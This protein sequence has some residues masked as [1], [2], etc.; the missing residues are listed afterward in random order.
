M[1]KPSKQNILPGADEALVVQLRQE[2]ISQQQ[3][4]QS[5]TPLVQRF[6]ETQA[7]LVAD[8]LVQGMSQLRF[9]LPDKVVFLVGRKGEGQSAPLP[10]EFREQLVG[11]LMDR[12][13]GMDIRAAMRQRLAELEQSVN[14]AVAASAGLL[15]YATV[16]HMV[17]SMLPAGKSV[18]Y[19]VD[20]EDEIPNIPAGSDLEVDSAITAIT[21]AIAEEA[22]VEDGRGELLV[23]Y[24]S[25]ARA[26]F[27][28]QWVAFDDQGK[29]LVSSVN[30]AEAHV[31]SMQRYLSILHTAVAIAPYTVADDEYQRRRYGI[32]GQLVNQ[33]RAL[34]RYE[35]QEI[36]RTVWKRAK[37]QD[38]NRGVSLSLPYFDDQKL[39]VEVHRFEVI[40]AGRIM[41]VPA[42]V[43]RATREQ[44]AKVAQD[45]RL[46][47]ST[48]RHLLSELREVEKAF[49]TS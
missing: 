15:R 34:A 32:L 30:E 26:F 42:F 25:A 18:T 2:Y 27:L 3:L 9:S 24:I 5:Q 19:L 10:A 40:P 36:V 4:Y 35:V 21:D 29:I 1:A 45:T 22:E 11:G 49:E 44:Q 39:A 12:L 38:L 43:V 37:A 14:P 16:A 41:F 46:S 7:A 47:P 8:A 23:P 17:Y 48:R 33:G 28:P 31:A 6:F 20:A 13:T